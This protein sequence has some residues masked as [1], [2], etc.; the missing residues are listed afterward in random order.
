MSASV[1]R[2]GAGDILRQVNLEFMERAYA[3]RLSISAALETLDPSSEHPNE[4]TD[5]FQRVMAHAKIVTRSVPGI[6]LAADTGDDFIA[7]ADKAAGARGAGHILFT[8]HLTRVWKGASGRDINTRAMYTSADNALGTLA[9][10]YVDTSIARWDKQLAPQIPISALVA[11]TTPVDGN[12]Y[13]AFYLTDDASNARMVR[14]SEFAE[15]PGA[16][17]TGGDRVIYLHKYGRKI[18]MSYEQMRR[19]RIDQVAMHVGRLAVQAEVDKLAVVIDVAVNGDGNAG[20]AATSYNLTTLDGSTTAN[21]L[22]LLA[23]LTF[24]AKFLNPYVL[25]TVIGQETP[26][27]KLQMLNTGNA[28]IPLVFLPGNLF[29]GLRPISPQLAQGQSFG[30][31]TDAPSGKLIGLDTRLAVAQVTEIGATIQE[32]QRFIGNQT[33]AMTMTETEGWH[34]LD[35]NA[36]KILNLAA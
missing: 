36:T 21:N 33:E 17:L 16:K 26:I 29:G 18:T 4:R 24:K 25:D 30:I 7:K 27:I 11:M 20:T 34:I 1:T 12:T 5:A 6:G 19:M 3:E 9:N 22:T 28:N 14:V 15:I 23:W 32:V 8:E 31:T 35:G 10:P 13:R 2:Q